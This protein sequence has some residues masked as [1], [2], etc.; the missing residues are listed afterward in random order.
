MY[1]YIWIHWAPDAQRVRAAMLSLPNE[2]EKVRIQ[3]RL[4]AAMQPLPGIVSVPIAAGLPVL[5]NILALMH[6]AAD[7]SVMTI[8][9][10]SDAGKSFQIIEGKDY[11]PVLLSTTLPFVVFDNVH[12]AVPILLG[13]PGASP[14]KLMRVPSPAASLS[15]GGG[16]SM[17]DGE[18]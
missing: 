13:S 4:A 18:S 16:G 7:S 1:L 9:S 6:G 14:A 5:L 2:S 17:S 11:T 8:T 10:S 15:R 12:E 3:A